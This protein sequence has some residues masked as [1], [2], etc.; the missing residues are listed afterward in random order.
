VSHH[1]LESISAYA[2]GELSAEASRA[3]ESHLA[4]C[5]ECA[6]ELTLI[7]AM[8]GAM[9]AS[10]DVPPAATSWHRVHRSITR[11]FGWLLLVAGGSVWAVLAL[12]EW[13]R[14][15]APTAAWLASTAMGVGLALLAVGIGY[16]QYRAWKDEPYKHIER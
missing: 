4:V 7:R 10:L 9:K 16:E 13:F 14:A 1:P 8:G 6:R 11:P 3:V 5:T 12:V 15:G 2:D